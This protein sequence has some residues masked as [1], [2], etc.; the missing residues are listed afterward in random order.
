MRAP[1]EQLSRLGDLPRHQQSG[2]T[3]AIRI[4]DGIDGIAIIQLDNSDVIRHKL[5]TKIITAYQKSNIED[6]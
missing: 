4:L 3:Q 5:V 1:G 2:L 6:D